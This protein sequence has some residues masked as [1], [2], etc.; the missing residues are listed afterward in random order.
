MNAFRRAADR[1]PLSTPTWVL[2]PGTHQALS[3]HKAALMLHTLERL[4]SWEVMQRVLSTFFKRWQYK[5][6][7]PD[8]F[9]AVLS[10]VTSQDHAW[11]V[12]QVYRNSNTFDYGIERLASENIAWRGLNDTNAF[13]DQTLDK[14]WRTT[15]V[16]RRIGSG[17]FPVDVL[18]TFSDGHQERERWDG[19]ARWQNFSYDRPARAVSAQVDPERVLLLDTNFTNNSF[20][21]EPS[22]GRA[23]AK[24]AATWL[25]WLQDQLLTWA[26]FV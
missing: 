3:Y 22:S 17:Q 23:A 15:V 21:T 14:L 4:H 26:F 12:E 2:W 16:A 9:F 19:R 18:V 10:E 8:D 1:D 7:T 5:H 24:W 20:T 25:V 11:F 13:E 6:P